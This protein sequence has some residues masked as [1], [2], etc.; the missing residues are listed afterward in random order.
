MLLQERLAGTYIKLASL[1]S[2]LEQAHCNRDAFCV[3]LQI[4]PNIYQA[5]HKIANTWNTLHPV[6]KAACEPCLEHVHKTAHAVLH[7]PHSTLDV[8]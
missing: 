4:I 6:H 2:L 1:C 8:P 5:G 3:I 7:A